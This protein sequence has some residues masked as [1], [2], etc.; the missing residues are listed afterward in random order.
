MP[1]TETARVAIVY[2]SGYGHTAQ[3]ARAV[4]RGVEQVDGA[5]HGD[6]PIVVIVPCEHA[7]GRQPASAS[8]H[9]DRLCSAA[10]CAQHAAGVW[11]AWAC[12]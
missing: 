12:R 10:P 5:G 1:S 8:A 6:R 7:V 9:P 3:H 11:R 4:K 2:H